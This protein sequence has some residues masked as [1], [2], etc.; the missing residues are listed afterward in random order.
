M[1]VLLLVDPV[2]KFE[3]QPTPSEV[4]AAEAEG[5]ATIP[6]ASVVVILLESDVND[7]SGEPKKKRPKKRTKQDDEVQVIA[8]PTVRFP[9]YLKRPPPIDT[10]LLDLRR[11]VM[12]SQ[13]NYYTA[14][15]RFFEQ[16]TSTLPHIKRMIADMP[17]GKGVSND[18][19]NQNV[20]QSEHAYAFPSTSGADVESDV[21]I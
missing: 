8:E 7:K 3:A 21:D 18:K 15:T 13:V 10:K 16:A 12:I 6:T 1:L 17:W 14:S 4:A 9:D 19:V 11:H 5:T 20:N 2:I